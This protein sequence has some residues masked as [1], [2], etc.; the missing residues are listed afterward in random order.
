[1]GLTINDSGAAI[2][3]VSTFFLLL[4][5]YGVLPA[6]A[7]AQR[8]HADLGDH[9]T[10]LFVEDDGHDRSATDKQHWSINVVSTF[11]YFFSTFETNLRRTPSLSTSFLLFFYF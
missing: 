9:M 8:I 6:M 3:V 11:F 4:K 5:R 2:N 10:L 7:A 1:L